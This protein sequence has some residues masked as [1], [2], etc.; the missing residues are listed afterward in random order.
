[1]Q[2]GLQVKKS[3]QIVSFSHCICYRT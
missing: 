1:M 3:I 2:G